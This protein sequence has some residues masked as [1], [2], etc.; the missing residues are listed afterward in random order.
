VFGHENFRLHTIAQRLSALATKLVAP[1]RPLAGTPDASNDDAPLELTTLHLEIWFDEF[2]EHTISL[3]DYIANVRAEIAALR[4]DA[5][6]APHF[7]ARLPVLGLR[8]RRRQ[9]HADA[10]QAAQWCLNWAERR[11]GFSQCLAEAEARWAQEI[12]PVAMAA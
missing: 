3:E 9:V 10:L 1:F 4:R 5:D 11:A 6:G 7:A 2:V 12:R 8:H